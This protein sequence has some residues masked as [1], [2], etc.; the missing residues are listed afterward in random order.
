MSIRRPQSIVTLILG[1]ALFVLGVLSLISNL[2]I[3]SIIPLLIG[4]SLIYLGWAGTRT[5]LIVFGHACIVVGC[6]L[7]TW[8]LYLIPY[9]KPTLLHVF[10]R[11]LF[12]GF[13][14]LFGGICAIYHAF[15]NCVKCPKRD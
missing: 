15:C 5:A 13:F 12:W 10:G 3:G 7:I 8:G 14:C 11:P 2:S 9:C 6:F 4:I 1:I